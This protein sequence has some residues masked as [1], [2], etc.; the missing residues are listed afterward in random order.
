MP[1][2]LITGAGGGIGSA[3]ATALAPTHT[4]LLAGRPSARLD[5]VAEQLGATTW[6]LDLADADEIEVNFSDGSKLKAE[7]VGTD[8]K[9]DIAL[10]KVDAGGD[11]PT[12]KFGDSDHLRVGEWVLAMGN[13]FGLGGTATSGIVSARGRQIALGAGG[14]V[15]GVLVHA[16]EA[17]ATGCCIQMLASVSVIRGRE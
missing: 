15:F 6:P 7:I 8:P 11:L 2:A 14:L 17:V 10:L 16:V 9:T 4:L 3:I 13:P 1:T 12:V 5:A